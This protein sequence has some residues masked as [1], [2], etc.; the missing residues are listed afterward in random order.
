VGEAVAAQVD[1]LAG[2]VT[3]IAGA[4][5]YATSL[6]AADAARAD[7][8]R[9]A[10]VWLATGRNWPD[11]LV[12][13]PAIA[14]IGGTFMLVDGQDLAGSPPTEQLLRAV[15]PELQ[16]LVL[17]GGVAAISADVETQIQALLR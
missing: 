12:T 8:A 2:S 13:G 4:D 10:T 17:I 15:A 16:R 11:A 14:H 9:S 1:A 3:R 5:R 6:A 7:G